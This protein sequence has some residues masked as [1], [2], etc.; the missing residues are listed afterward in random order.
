M[1]TKDYKFFHGIMFHHFHDDKDYLKSQGSISK[2]DLVNLIKFVGRKNI[3]DADDFIDRFKRKKL[4]TNNVCFTFDDS[5]K[6]QYSVALPILEEMKIKAFF[7][8]YS[9]V[10]TSK[11]DMLEIY[12]Y[13]R[14]NYYKSIDEFYNKFFK[15]FSELYIYIH[16]F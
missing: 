5:L 15:I 14:M 8:V 13:F 9:S 4:S 2:D 6:C 7:F 12:R 10:F 16:F 3:L 11:P 1:D